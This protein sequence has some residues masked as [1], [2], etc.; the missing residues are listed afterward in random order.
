MALI[1]TDRGLTCPLCHWSDGAA[2]SDHE[3]IPATSR[4][5]RLVFA[6]LASPGPRY[7]DLAYIDGVVAY[8]LSIDR[9]LTQAE[10]PHD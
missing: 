2:I 1:P 7:S 10:K 9:E 8:A 6:L 3:T 4:V 5:E